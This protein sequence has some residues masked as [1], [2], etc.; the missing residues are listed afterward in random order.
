MDNQ[1]SILIVDDQKVM[2]DT[3]A[4][5]LGKDNYRL[6]FAENGPSAI[7]KAVEIQPD[8]ILLDVMMPGMDGFE[9]CRHIRKHPIISAVPI[10]MV[11]AL[12]DR[13]SWVEGIE[14]GADDFVFK[15]LDTVELRT[16]VKNITQ[17]NRYRRL[18]VERLKF[19]WVIEQAN[20]G[21]LM[22]N[23]Q[24][25]I[26]YA[27]PKGRQYLSLSD[28]S[29]SE[30]KD[31]FF[32]LA[33]KQYQLEPQE[34]WEAWPNE[35]VGEVS[36]YL[37]RPETQTAKAFW[38]QVEQLD[39]PPG[40]DIARLIRLR[41]V[42]EQMDL[43]RDVWR[44]HYMV[45]HKLRTPLAVILNS[46]ELLARH[47]PSLEQDKV[48]E[49]TERALT[50]GQRLQGGVDDVLEFVQA[51]SLAKPGMGFDLA[52]LGS[53]TERLGEELGIESLLIA[54]LDKLYGTQVVLSSQAIETIL[55]EV[56]EN[57]KKFH[58]DGEPTVQVFASPLKSN[59]VGIWIGDNGLTLPQ[60]QLAQ[61]W[62][63]YYQGEK[64][65]TGE[66]S[67]MGLGLPLVAMLVWGVGGHCRMYNRPEEPGV[68]VELML[69]VEEG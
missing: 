2:R 34:A 60:E 41:D 12:N 31:T 48:I 5:L 27:N 49:L 15:P 50:G 23:R 17:L 6:S 55:R 37:V 1:S 67:G 43:Q 8:I 45:F 54:G 52:E 64:M 13:K 59:R 47:A 58:P 56:L 4:L 35:A 19:D 28:E 22:L 9:V 62:T 44:F 16:R 38:L 40:V 46:L 3:V 57:A 11:T 30:G 53:L 61:A 63:P 26:V 14:S 33:Q 10:I 29:I 69:P 18:L 66:V 65:F 20:E 32:D 42:S 7:E 25:K 21:Y 51:T 68:V 24:E 36:R 39:L